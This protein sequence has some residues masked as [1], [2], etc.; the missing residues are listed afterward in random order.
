MAETIIEEMLTAGVIPGP[1]AHHAVIFAYVKAGDADG[2]LTAIRRTHNSGNADA[3]CTFHC[4]HA[5]QKQKITM[6]SS[7]CSF[8]R[9][10]LLILHMVTDTLC[11]F[12]YVGILAVGHNVINCLWTYSMHISMVFIQKYYWCV[13]KYR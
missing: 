4:T 9:S 11:L 2:A 5:E 8:P 6:P 10:H 12:V 7:G 3:H 1:K 13:P